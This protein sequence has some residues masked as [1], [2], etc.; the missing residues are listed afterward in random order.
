MLMRL[1]LSLIV[2]SV[3]CFG[4][5]T[6]EKIQWQFA[7]NK[8]SQAVEAKA[9]IASGWHLYSQFIE[10][11]T[12]P[13]ATQF[14]IER[15]KNVTLIGQFNEPDPIKHY[16]ETFDE[17]LTYF[18]KSAIFSQKITFTAP[19]ILKGS[20]VFMLCNDSMCLPPEEKQFTIELN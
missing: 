14:Q 20:V 10:P 4:G 1:I 8:Q 3:F 19:T 16:D 13:V 7:Y 2:F 15:N 11:G 17:E 9:I 5:M 18:E 6:Q 12:G